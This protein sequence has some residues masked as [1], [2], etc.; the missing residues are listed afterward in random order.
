MKR[1]YLLILGASVLGI[2]VVGWLAS[3]SGIFSQGPPLRGFFIPLASPPVLPLPSLSL[4]PPTEAL[5]PP[6]TEPCPEGYYY[7]SGSECKLCGGIGIPV[8]PYFDNDACD[9]ICPLHCGDGILS[10]WEECDDGNTSNT[11]ACLNTCVAATCGDG[12]TW[13]GREECDDGNNVSDDGCSA[14]CKRENRNCQCVGERVKLCNSFCEN[15]N[16][17]C[18]NDGD[19]N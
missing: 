19:C 13:E 8:P 2:V 10:A 6:T 17:L 15:K 11:D 12:H 1:E 14:D 18:Q 16:T 9:G 3:T 4:P 5:P 7:C